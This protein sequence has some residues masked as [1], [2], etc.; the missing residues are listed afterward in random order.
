MGILIVVTNA[1]LE[2]W[3][4]RQERDGDKATELIEASKETLK[5]FKAKSA[6]ALALK[7]KLDAL[8]EEFATPPRLLSLE[9]FVFWVEV[10]I[11]VP[12]YVNTS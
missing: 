4:T 1:S 3:E 6:E 9:D 10:R 12:V 5:A 2:D 7:A 8:Q 11:A